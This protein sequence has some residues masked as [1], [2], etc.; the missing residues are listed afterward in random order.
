VAALVCVYLP[1]LIQGAS[2][3]LL[4]AFDAD[5]ALDA[6][7]RHRCTYLFALPACLQLMAEEQTERPRNISSLRGIFAG[8]DSVSVAL[9][10]RVREQFHVELVEGYGMTEVV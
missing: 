7:E 9:Q 1:G 6:I 4:R 8:G 2:A 3:M 10:R 5:A